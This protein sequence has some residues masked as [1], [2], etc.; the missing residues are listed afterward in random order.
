MMIL[1]VIEIYTRLIDNKLIQFTLYDIQAYSYLTTDI[2]DF[3][4]LPL[5]IFGNI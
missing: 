3:Q 5:Q 4:G 2:A 1:V